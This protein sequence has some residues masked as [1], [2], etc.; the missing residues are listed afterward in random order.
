MVN[1]PADRKSVSPH[2][3]RPIYKWPVI[4][5]THHWIDPWG[6]PP[7]V[8][9]FTGK[10]STDGFSTHIS[11]KHPSFTSLYPF[12]SIYTSVYHHLHPL[13]HHFHDTGR[14]NLCV[15]L[16]PPTAPTPSTPSSCTSD[17]S[18]Q[19]PWPGSICQALSVVS[20]ASLNQALVAA[21]RVQKITQES[22][23]HHF[24]RSFEIVMDSWM[25]SWFI[26]CV[27]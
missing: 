3:V 21:T 9:V 5:F 16:L 2:F 8:E 14:W 6:D 7:S 20:Q 15:F 4:P 1:N 12:T 23:M 13:T 19:R 24:W 27:I 10:S 17:D 11:Q 26:N 25:L 18:S 22:G